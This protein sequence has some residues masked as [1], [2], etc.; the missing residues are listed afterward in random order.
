[1]IRLYL[2][3]LFKS[4]YSWL[5]FLEA[6]TVF[7]GSCNWTERQ[8]KMVSSVCKWWTLSCF[9]CW[10][11][12]IVLFSSIVG[13]S[14]MMQCMLG[15]IYLYIFLIL[16]LTE[17]TLFYSSLCLQL[18]SCGWYICFTPTRPFYIIHSVQPQCQLLIRANP[19]LPW[20]AVLTNLASAFPAQALTASTPLDS[21]WRTGLGFFFVYLVLF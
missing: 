1:M 18:K 19:A 3:Y 10:N 5:L 21:M 8:R 2:Q 7:P 11:W 17:P 14:N 9:P 12:C 6:L 4:G 16:P 15:S 20:R 13:I